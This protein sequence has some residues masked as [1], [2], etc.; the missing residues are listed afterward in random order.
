MACDGL[1]AAGLEF[2]ANIRWAESGKFF[3][4]DAV[5]NA[6]VCVAEQNLSVNTVKNHNRLRRVLDDGAELR[7]AGSERVSALLNAA[8]E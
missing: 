2:G 5:K 6:C 3:H 1:P 4:R 8:L 7:F